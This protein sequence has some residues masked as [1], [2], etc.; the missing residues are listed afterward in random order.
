MS[1]EY[2]QIMKGIAI[3]MMVWLH[4]FNNI[5]AAQYYADLTIGTRPLAWLL[6]GACNPVGIFIALGGYGLYCVYLK[7]KDEHHVSRIIK[8]YGHYW[9]ITA[10]FIAVGSIGGG[11]TY[12]SDLQTIIYNITGLRT[13]W[14]GECWFLLPYSILSLSYPIIFRVIGRCRPWL[15][16]GATFI[17]SFLMMALLHFYHATI[18]PNPL[19]FLPVALVE[20]LFCFCC[21]ALAKKYAV[22]ERFNGWLRRSGIGNKSLLSILCVLILVRI[23]IPHSSWGGIFSLTLLLLLSAIKYQTWTRTGL[24]FLGAHSMNIWMI[25]TWF[26]YYLFHDFFYGF[27][28]PIL[29]FAATLGASILASMLVN[30]IFVFVEKRPRKRVN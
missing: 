19:L 29:I 16:V 25:H 28:Y 6:A 1:K 12:L 24:A 2:T 22:I 3:M 26:C 27:N 8:L 4:L 9:L 17:G 21:G 5:S 23:L 7:E 18:S 20:F 15:V 14:N 30:A 10:T 11:I 13:T